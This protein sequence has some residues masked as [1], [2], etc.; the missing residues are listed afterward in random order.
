MS[1]TA[2]KAREAMKAKAK[3]LASADPQ[4]KVSSTTWT[5]PEALDGDVKTGAR[6]LVKRLYKK[7]GKVVGKCEG[8]ATKMRADRKARKSG[9]RNRPMST[10][11][12]LNRDVRMAN[13]V[14]EG[15]KHTGAFKKGG[16]AH[17]L[18]G[19]PI[20]DNPI[21]SQNRSMGKAAGMAYKKGGKA[22]RE[23]HANGNMAGEDQ[24]GRM[25]R[26]DEKN[27]AMDEMVNRKMFE[28]KSG[29][30]PLPPRRK[31]EPAPKEKVMPE[32]YLGS[33]GFGYKKGGEAKHPDVKEDKALIKKMVKPEART[34]KYTGGGVFSGNSKEKVPGAVGGRDAH[35]KGG[36]VGK[37]KTNI[38]III[39]AGG[40]A[41]KPE[42]G[43]GMMPN[44]PMNAPPRPLPVP[45]PAPAGAGGPPM[46]MPPMGGPAGPAGAG[47]P[48]MPPMGM[49]RKSGG[50]TIHVID[51]AAGGGLGRQEKID[52]YGL[53]PPRRK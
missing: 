30:V 15:K 29:N 52:A 4:T 11:D 49:A 36:K 53:K 35:K 18:G 46:P 17:K 45:P 25:I 8:G 21:S 42:L 41:P 26:A 43:A 24:I 12:F 50:R 22:K 10:D 34:G 44:E 37:G 33:K 48:P 19:G 32:K 38:N 16:K 27:R 31:P 20:G 14:R 3:R 2:K 5:P 7:G 9:G 6:P 39:G 40:M 1:E 28:D 47:G 13:D 51:H 23:R